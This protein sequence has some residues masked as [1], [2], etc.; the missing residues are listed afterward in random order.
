MQIIQS[1]IKERQPR[2]SL[3]NRE[4]DVNFHAGVFVTLNPA[5]K[6]YGGR[7]RLPDNL[8]QLFRPVA[9]SRPD[10]EL[11]AEVIL[12]SEGFTSASLLGRKVVTIYTIAS[13]LMTVQ[14]H[15][16]WGLRALKTCLTSAGRLLAIRVQQATSKDP[17]ISRRLEEDQEAELVMQAIMINTM[18]K[19]TQEDA[20]NFSR[21]VQDVFPQTKATQLDDPRLLEALTTVMARAPSNFVSETPQVCNP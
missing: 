14:I 6:G 1:A 17:G 20:R 8:K 4:I 9:M 5:G 19:L 12:A 13:Q 16:D 18:P 2:I 10:N 7:S 11:I 15:Y 3:I 21:L